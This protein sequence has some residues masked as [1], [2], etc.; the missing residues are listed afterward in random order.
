VIDFGIDQLIYEFASWVHI[1]LSN[2]APR[3]QL[4]TIDAAGTRLGI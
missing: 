1:G 4:L 2:A 3:H